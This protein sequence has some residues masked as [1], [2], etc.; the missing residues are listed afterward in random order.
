MT[1][2][3]FVPDQ[4]HMTYSDVRGVQVL[5]KHA[6]T[7]NSLHSRAGSAVAAT[8]QVRFFLRKFGADTRMRPVH[9]RA[10]GAFYGGDTNVI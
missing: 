8:T 5:E 7:G 6:M 3:G 9:S 1:R 10:E 2:F 4:S